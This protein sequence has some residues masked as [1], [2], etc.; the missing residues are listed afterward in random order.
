M[1]EM[2]RQLTAHKGHSDSAVLAAVRHTAGA[3][4]NLEI[5]ELLHHVVLANRFWLLSIQGRPFAFDD[6]SHRP[7][8]LH[9]IAQRYA[10]THQAELDWLVNAQEIDLARTLENSLIPGGRCSV[11]QAWMQVC[12]HS[13]GH[14][15]QCALLLRRHGVVPPAID[16]ITWLPS[17][18]PASWVA[19][20]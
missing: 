6:E 2:L 4:T 15:A 9:E 5:L 13:H 20:V 8:S 12:M 14:R 10:V 19:N 3:A 18:A 16:F 7:E 11:A 17:R 1:L